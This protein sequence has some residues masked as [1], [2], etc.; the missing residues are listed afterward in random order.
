MISKQ[1]APVRNTQLPSSRWELARVVNVHPGS[2]GHVGVTNIR[3]AQSQ[4]KR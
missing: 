2:D 1:R 4:Y 3:T